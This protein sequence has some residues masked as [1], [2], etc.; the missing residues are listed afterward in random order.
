MP[1]KHMNRHVKKT[2]SA[3]R[4]SECRCICLLRSDN[5]G[6]LL[7][8]PFTERFTARFAI[9]PFTLLCFTF[10]LIPVPCREHANQSDEDF[11]YVRWHHDLLLKFSAQK[12]KVASSERDIERTHDYKIS[13]GNDLANLERVLWMVLC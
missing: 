10:C 8:S 4:F 9:C 11:Y 1:S 6:K 2:T 13:V 5:I 7:W 3:Q 12:R